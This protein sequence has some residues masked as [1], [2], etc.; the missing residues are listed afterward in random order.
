MV[1]CIIKSCG[2]NVYTGR[3]GIYEFSR[4]R[5][6]RRSGSTAQCTSN[7]RNRCEWL[8][9]LPGRFSPGEIARD[10]HFIG[11]SGCPK[12]CVETVDSAYAGNRTPIPC[13]FSP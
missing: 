8:G 10:V 3:P 5:N 1:F 6:V 2:A 4:Y 13:L 11:G 12:V 7:L 9:S